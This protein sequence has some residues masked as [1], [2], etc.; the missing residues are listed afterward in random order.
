MTNVSDSA[1]QALEVYTPSSLYEAGLTEDG[2]PFVAHCFHVGIEAKNG[3]RWFHIHS[4]PG[5]ES[6]YDDEY[7]YSGFRDISEE[8]KAKADKLADKVRAH[9][10]AGKKLDPSHW[11]EVDPRY[12][13]TAYESLDTLGFFKEREKKEDGER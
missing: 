4:F 1:P 2:E 3:Q 8:A 10:S 5:A 6:Y 11:A 9:L 12:G 7:D 13:S